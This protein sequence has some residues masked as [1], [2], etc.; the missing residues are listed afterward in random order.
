MQSSLPIN[1]VVYLKLAYEF[2][3]QNEIS[4]PQIYRYI[5]KQ[6]CYL[7]IDFIGFI[8]RMLI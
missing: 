6:A 1:F 4:I 8:L 5:K 3:K 2:V 7:Q